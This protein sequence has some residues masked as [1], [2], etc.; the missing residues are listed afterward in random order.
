MLALWAAPG[1]GPAFFLSPQSLGNRRGKQPHPLP[2]FAPLRSL[3]QRR[4]KPSVHMEYKERLRA[5]KNHQLAFQNY[6]P[7]PKYFLF[8]CVFCAPVSVSVFLCVSVS[9]HVYSPSA[10][11]SSSKT[12]EGPAGVAQWIERRPA[13]QGVAGLI[14]SQGTCLGCGPGPQWG[15]YERQPHMDVSLPFFLP[16]FPS[17]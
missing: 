2:P 13:N 6:F 8:Y 14:P 9:V 16:P 3:K 17:L 15:P 4:S 7:T 11:Q 1:Q 5:T 12:R 10:S